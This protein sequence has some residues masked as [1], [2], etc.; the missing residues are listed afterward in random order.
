MREE[1]M[2][3]Q[4][5]PPTYMTVCLFFQLLLHLSQRILSLNKT[6]ET[7]LVWVSISD[8]GENPPKAKILVSCKAWG[9]EAYFIVWEW[10][11]TDGQALWNK[12]E[13]VPLWAG[14]NVSN[15]MPSQIHQIWH[16]VLHI[17]LFP[18]CLGSLTKWIWASKAVKVKSALLQQPDFVPFSQPW[19]LAH[20]GEV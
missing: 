19:C 7:L 10:F 12:E 4:R 11:D 18:R 6:A 8:S 20:S 1:G 14:W 16:P 5:D 3:C 2:S 15:P 9:L 13:S 17:T